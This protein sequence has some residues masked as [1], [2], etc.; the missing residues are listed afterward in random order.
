MIR[1]PNSSRQ[2]VDFSL[3]NSTDP[4][5]NSLIAHALI[6]PDLPYPHKNG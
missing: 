1:N 4:R 5:E 6:H 3:P 2:G